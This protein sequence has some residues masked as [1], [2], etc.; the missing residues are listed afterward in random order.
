M[1]WGMAGITAIAPLSCYHRLLRWFQVC[2]VQPNATERGGFEP[3]VPC[4]TLDFES[5]AFDHSATSPFRILLR[6]V[7]LSAIAL[8]LEGIDR[9]RPAVHRKRL[10]CFIRY[11]L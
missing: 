7:P 4:G 11:L 9:D 1:K 2:Q 6:T 10:C 3:P 5:S 8:H